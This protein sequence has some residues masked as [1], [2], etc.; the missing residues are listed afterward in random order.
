VLQPARLRIFIVMAVI[1]HI[2]LAILFSR[3]GLSFP[4]PQTQELSLVMIIQGKGGGELIRS[5]PVW[6]MPKRIERQFPA[7]RAV[8]S[9]EADI[10]ARARLD[11]P[12]VS[13]LLPGSFTPPPLRT[14][15]LA[16][17][18]GPSP[19]EELFSHLPAE[20]KATPPVDFALP[21]AI[22]KTFEIGR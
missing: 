6:P 4:P 2:T 1:M 16:A 20:S 19:P 7:E 12:D 13:R 17:N 11:M 3:V 9:L 8:G 15:E 22:P 5:E 10:K 21:P 18:A 14:S